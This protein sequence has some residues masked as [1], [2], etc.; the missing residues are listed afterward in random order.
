M[1][2][3]ST[4]TREAILAATRA[5]LREHGHDELSMAKVAA[6]FDG[7]QSLIHYHFDDRE[8]LLTAFLERERERFAASLADLPSEPDERLTRLVDERIAG[9]GEPEPSSLVGGYLGLHAAALDSEPIRREL[10]ALDE[11]LFEAFRE[12]VA[13]GVETGVFRE[14]DPATVAQVLIAGHDSA[15]L[16][17][18]VDDDPATVRD[19]VAET[20]LANLRGGDR[21]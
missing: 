11:A 18:T 3:D 7:S 6:E 10:A 15:F 16:R 21:A 17:V 1:N 9:L 13:R 8:G 12:T 19:A 20:V 2:D 5:A 4:E 14:C